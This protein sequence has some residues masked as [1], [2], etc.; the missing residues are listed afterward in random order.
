M[1]E[2]QK[3]EAN[4]KM[5]PIERTNVVSK[6]NEALDKRAYRKISE[7]LAGKIDDLIST[8]V[9]SAVCCIQG[10]CVSWCCIRVIVE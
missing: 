4:Q 10:C 2:K 3:V 8:E 9:S 5:K 6:A 7:G 1:E